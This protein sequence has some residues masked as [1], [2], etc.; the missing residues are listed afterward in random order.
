M[1][2][3]SPEIAHEATYGQLRD[4]LG[5]VFAEQDQPGGTTPLAAQTRS[6][7]VHGSRLRTDGCRLLLVRT[8]EPEPT[9][10]AVL[11]DWGGEVVSGRAYPPAIPQ[12][13]GAQAEAE[14][15]HYAAMLA[16]IAATR[17]EQ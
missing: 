7:F 15:A 8:A 10:R 6:G 13:E 5:A 12:A 11:T 3:K 9:Y 4:A 14:G 1:S 17:F 2:V 16:I